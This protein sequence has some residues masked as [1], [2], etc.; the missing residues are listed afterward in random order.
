VTL[1]I[2][3]HHETSSKTTI[4]LQLKLIGKNVFD[5]IVRYAFK[6]ESLVA[7]VQQK[8]PLLVQKHVLA[9]LRFAQKY[10]NWSIYH[11]KV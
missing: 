10:T 6:G 1:V 3:G 9:W 4:E 11:R 5:T 2:E 8:K 7:H